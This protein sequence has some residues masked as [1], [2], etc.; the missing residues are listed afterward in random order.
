M[1]DEQKHM[2]LRADE[3][4]SIAGYTFTFIHLWTFNLFT[5][6]FPA[7]LNQHAS[8]PWGIFRKFTT[9]EKIVLEKSEQ[10]NH[11]R[12]DRNNNK[13]TLHIP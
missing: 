11:D 5:T 13:W 4:P 9:E 6:T 7:R 12:L 1:N 10:N 8:F 3:R 2:S